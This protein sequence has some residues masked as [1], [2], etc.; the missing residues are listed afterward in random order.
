MSKEDKKNA[1][2]KKVIGS[3]FKEFRWAIKKNQ[4]ELA[5]ELKVCQA[6]IASIETGNSFPGIT[7]Q[8]YLYDQYHMNI[9]WLL[10]GKEDMLISPPEKTK[11]NDIPLLFWHIDESDPRFKG[12][13]ELFNLMRVPV[14][15]RIILGKLAEIKALA[16]EEIKS[17]F[18]ET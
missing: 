4:Y 12:Y 10:T 3:R 15:E 2:L 6:T 5:K 16:E 18:E 13:V 17:F 11:E 9:N 14:I 1:A 7:F 8:N